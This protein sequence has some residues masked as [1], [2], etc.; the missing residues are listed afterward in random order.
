MI[1]AV[2]IHIVLCVVAYV[3]CKKAKESEWALFFALCLF[4]YLGPLFIVYLYIMHRVKEITD[5]D[6]NSYNG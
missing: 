3:L 4:P 2:L 6:D 5:K 1:W